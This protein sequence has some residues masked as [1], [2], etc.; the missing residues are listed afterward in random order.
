MLFRSATGSQKKAGVA[1]LIS[2]KLD[3]KLKVVTRDEEGHYIIIMESIYQEELTIINVYAPN[4]GAPKCIKELIA[5]ISNLMDKNV[6][7]AG[8]FNTPLTEVDRSSRQR[9]NKETRALND[10]LDQMDMTHIFRTLHPKATEYTFFS[11][12]HGKFSNI[13][14]ILCHKTPLISIKELRSYHAHFQTTML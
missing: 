5:N 3:F 10:T 12:T 6:V 1:I 13:D 9:I 14:H 4:T 8:D 7:I 2:D 11:S